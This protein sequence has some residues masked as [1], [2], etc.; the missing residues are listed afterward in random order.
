[1]CVPGAIAATGYTIQHL[2]DPVAGCAAC[3]APAAVAI[4]AF[5][6]YLPPHFKEDRLPVLHQLIRDHPLAT[7]VTLGPDGLVAN[8]I[9]MEIEPG[10]ALGVLRGHVARANPVWR[11]APEASG[12]NRAKIGE[13]QPEASRADKAVEALAIFQGAQ[14]YVTPAWYRT[15]AE[16]GKVVPTWNY[17]VVHASGPL[18]AIDD[19]E[20]LRGF[21]TRLTDHHEGRRR[22]GAGEP[23]RVT[24]APEDYVQRQLGGIVG[25]EMPL[26]RLEGKW[27]MSQNRPGE[28]RDAVVA[29]LRAAGDPAS[30]ALA[31][32]VAESLTRDRA[33]APPEGGRTA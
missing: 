11:M 31:D 5:A 7:L 27:K 24:D 20:W 17:V 10:G 23:W 30:L 4:M 12:A 9:P 18:R 29:G 1:M 32:L 26:T 25:I 19:P 33:A 6:M 15:K 21:V 22:D 2:E 14:G 13:A 16:T 28:D 8:H 3:P